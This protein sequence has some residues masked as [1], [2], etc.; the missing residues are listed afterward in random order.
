METLPLTGVYIHPL[1][2]TC[3]Q[4]V[5]RMN[6]SIDLDSIVVV[7]SD[8][9]SGDLQEG[10]LAILNL[11]DGVYYGLNPVGSRIWSLLQAPKSVAEIRDTLLAEYNVETDVC[12]RELID[13][14]SHLS[15]RQLIEIHAAGK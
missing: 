1:F 8:Q 5:F 10:D 14:L 11:K 15:S 3:S 13:L 4:G 9:V 6:N 12:T 7:S 2:V